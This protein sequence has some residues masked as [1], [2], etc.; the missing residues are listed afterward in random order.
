MPGLVFTHS[1]KTVIAAVSVTFEDRVLLKP[2]HRNFVLDSLMSDAA[3]INIIEAWIATAV[4]GRILT[5]HPIILLRPISSYPHALFAVEVGGNEAQVTE[6]RTPR[7][8][9]SFAES[10]HSL[11]ETISVAAKCTDGDPFA[12]VVLSPHETEL[13]DVEEGRSL[14]PI[15]RPQ[16]VAARALPAAITTPAVVV[17]TPTQG[18][19][20]CAGEGLAH[21]P[22]MTHFPVK[23]EIEV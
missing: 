7:C 10:M 1:I 17:C 23:P 15:R 19:M 14:I 13:G 12:T 21:D 6:F 8:A 18:T 3:A 9:F 20:L 11:G 4:F 22:H 2:R 5:V 16:V